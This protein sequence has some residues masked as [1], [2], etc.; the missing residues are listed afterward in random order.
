MPENVSPH[1]VR[2]ALFTMIKKQLEAPNTFD[3]NDWLQLGIYRHQPGIAE[4]YISTGCL[5]LCL[6]ALL[7]LGLPA[8]DEFWK[9]KDEDWT[10]K[11]VWKGLPV[12]NDHA[13]P[14]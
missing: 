9:G 11:K 1:Q 2:A 12:P 8:S 14:D 13:I 5:Y 10:T 4:Y 6:Q 7:I 3:A